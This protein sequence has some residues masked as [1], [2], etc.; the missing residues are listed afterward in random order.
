VKVVG[1]DVDHGEPILT[2]GTLDAFVMV[3]TL[4]I[5][6]ISSDNGGITTTESSTGT[7]TGGIATGAAIEPGVIAAAKRSHS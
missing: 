1:T 3:G 2:I 4:T 7:I 5:L 6:V